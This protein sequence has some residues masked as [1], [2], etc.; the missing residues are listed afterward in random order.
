MRV[1]FF[2]RTFPYC[3][4]FP[5]PFRFSWS[6]TIDTYGRTPLDEWSA[7]R[8]S[9]YLHRTTQHGNT[10][11][12]NHALSGIRTR[13]RAA[14]EIGNTCSL[15]FRIWKER[16]HVFGKDYT[17]TVLLCVTVLLYMRY[18]KTL[19]QFSCNLYLLKCIIPY[20]ELRLQRSTCVRL[21][22][23]PLQII[24][25]KT[26]L[27]WGGVF[28]TEHVHWA[29]YKNCL[30]NIWTLIYV[31]MY[32]CVCVCVCLCKIEECRNNVSESAESA[33]PIHFISH[34]TTAK[35][36]RFQHPWNTPL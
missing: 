19:I 8:R 16:M 23:L 13:D 36:V 10:R 33:E 11:Y 18:A 17:F 26:G 1:L 21:F 29:M 5:Q 34:R 27:L 31:C 3:W 12:K 7:R 15:K 2:L 14:T 30:L 28:Y 32:A 9:L 24:G 25:N 35:I 6:H 22:G 4:G 20:S